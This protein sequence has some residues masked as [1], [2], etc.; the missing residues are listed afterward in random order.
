MNYDEGNCCCGLCGQLE[1]HYYSQLSCDRQHREKTRKVD[2]RIIVSRGDWLENPA[3]IKD[4]N[5][6][7]V[8][9]V[10]SSLTVHSPLFSVHKS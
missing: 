3:K 4:E 2:Y 6:G 9:Y 5:N 7:A 1:Q 10:G 8:V